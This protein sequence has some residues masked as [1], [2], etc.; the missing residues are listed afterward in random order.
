MQDA[1]LPLLLLFATLLLTSSAGFA[2]PAADNNKGGVH[3]VIILH[4]NDLH[5]HL[6][7]WTG[8][9]GELRSAALAVSPALFETC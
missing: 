6:T 8:W 5:G 3:K 9:E 4:T 1:I 7:V 2:Q